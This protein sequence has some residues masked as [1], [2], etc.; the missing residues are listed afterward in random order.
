MD[1]QQ[2]EKMNAEYERVRPRFTSKGRL[3]NSWC[4]ANLRT[5]VEEVRA[6]SMY[7]GLYEFPSSFIHTDAMALVSGSGFS[8]D[9]TSVPSLVNA[10]VALKMG[11]LSYAMTLSAVNQIAGLKLDDRLSE[12]FERLNQA[13]AGNAIR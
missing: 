6:A 8:D 10:S 1:T 7:W 5:M 12:A 2:L 9:V 13:S 3:R 11:I 4:Q